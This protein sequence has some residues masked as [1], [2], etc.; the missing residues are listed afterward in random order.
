MMSAEPTC[1]A[2]DLRWRI[3]WQRIAKDLTFER[4]AQNLGICTATA[5]NI[6]KIFEATTGEVDPKKPSKRPEIRKLDK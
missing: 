5:S 1:R 4:I 3:V 6:F 2:P